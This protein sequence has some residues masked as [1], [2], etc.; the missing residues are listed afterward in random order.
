MPKWNA[1]RHVPA[2]GRTPKSQKAPSFVR[3][4]AVQIRPDFRSTD[5]GLDGWQDQRN[6]R[7]HQGRKIGRARSSQ[8]RQG[9]VSDVRGDT[10]S[11]V[12]HDIARAINTSRLDQLAW[13]RHRSCPNS[14]DDSKV[15][16]STVGVDSLSWTAC[17]TNLG[18]SPVS[19]SMKPFE[20]RYGLRR[21][22]IASLRTGCPLVAGVHIRIDDDP[23]SNDVVGTAIEDVGALPSTGITVSVLNGLGSR[24]TGDLSEV[25]SSIL[26]E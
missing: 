4:E 13:V 5:T 15:K 2:S 14:L 3:V 7:F 23:L 24:R 22:Q 10:N 6:G 17:R 1:T 12:R 9:D 19:S 18:I 25:N 8:R 20:G 26:E 11:P 21:P 16:R